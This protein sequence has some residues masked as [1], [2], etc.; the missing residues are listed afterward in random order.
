[1]YA[2][3]RDSIYTAQAGDGLEELLAAELTELGAENSVPGFRFVRFRADFETLCRIV[4]RS[5]LATRILAPLIYF[6][7]PT[8]RALY[9]QFHIKYTFYNI[10][11][12]LIYNQ[13]ILI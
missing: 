1:M 5:R 7:C 9:F 8:D 11:D 3:Q 4:H 2:Y 13:L 12:I 6:P 10:P